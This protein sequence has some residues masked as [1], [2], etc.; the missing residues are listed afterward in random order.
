M[1]IEFEK[2][3]FWWG[4]IVHR[5]VEMPINANQHA[6]IDFGD[7]NTPNQSTN[8]LL[9]SK[10]RYLYSQEPYTATFNNGT[11]EID[12]EIT[13]RDG[14]ANLRGAYLAAMRAYFPFEN[15]LPDQHFFTMP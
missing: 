7:I 6:V 4:G 3:E 5:G 8:L 10:G 15:C 13:Y 11:V 1:K 14:Y 9:S 2:N 12:R